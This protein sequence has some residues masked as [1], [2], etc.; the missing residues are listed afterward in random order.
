L[1]IHRYHRFW[2]LNRKN[3]KTKVNKNN[4]VNNNKIWRELNNNRNQV[5]Y[6]VKLIKIIRLLYNF[7]NKVHHLFLKI[8]Y[9]KNNLLLSMVVMNKIKLFNLFFNI[10]VVKI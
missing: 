9:I 10:K 1:K 2:K 8:K 7:K 3:I 5:N 4:L 6:L